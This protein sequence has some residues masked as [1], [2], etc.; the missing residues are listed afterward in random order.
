M[1]SSESDLTAYELQKLQEISTEFSYPY[2]N[3]LGF[4]IEI[5]GLEI[6]RQFTET[7]RIDGFRGYCNWARK[8]GYKLMPRG[9]EIGVFLKYIK[10]A[11]KTTYE[12]AVEKY[13]K[14]L[15][16]HNS[17]RIENLKSIFE[18][19]NI[20]IRSLVYSNG[21]AIIALLSLMGTIWSENSNIIKITMPMLFY[22]GIGL[23]AILLTTFFAYL[24]QFFVL[25]ENYTY[26]K[27]FRVAAIV[28][29][30]SS[31]GLF[32]VG[33]IHTLCIII[34]LIP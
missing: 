6:R 20:G 11:D 33:I 16:F 23:S 19:T 31:W 28:T 15:D 2:T 9:K 29:A 32:T 24:A 30:L 12:H 4:Y 10:D 5:N 13:R 21:G 34:P 14:D 27:N 17:A 3:L 18:Y 22:F 1:E 7:Y 26:E 8:W 25:Q